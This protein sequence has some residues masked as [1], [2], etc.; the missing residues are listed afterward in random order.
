LQIATTLI[1][2]KYWKSNRNCTYEFD[3]KDLDKFVN[4]IENRFSEKLVINKINKSTKRPNK[5]VINDELKAFVWDN[6]EKRFEKR[7]ELI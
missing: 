3:L 6:F 7:N 1:S 2:E 4:F 5:I